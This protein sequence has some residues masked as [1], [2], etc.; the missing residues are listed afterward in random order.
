MNKA[1][2]SPNLTSD[3]RRSQFQDAVGKGGKGENADPAQSSP[4]AEASTASGGDVPV[5]KAAGTAD[6]MEDL[7]VV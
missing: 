5:D 2:P 6:V 3:Q 7:G 1:A 4:A